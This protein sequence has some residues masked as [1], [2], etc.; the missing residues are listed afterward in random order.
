[1]LPMRH[2]TNSVSGMIETLS[3]YDAIR[4]VVGPLPIY[5]S[6]ESSHCLRRNSASLSSVL[7]LT[8]VSCSKSFG[9]Q[10]KFSFYGAVFILFTYIEGWYR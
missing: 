6:T 3:G 9:N 1:M 4:A 8:F 5:A 7:A 10:H 2:K